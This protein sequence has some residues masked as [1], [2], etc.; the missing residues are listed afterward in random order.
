MV[1]LEC[2]YGN[3]HEMRWPDVTV[4]GT[5]YAVSL[6]ASESDEAPNH[7]YIDI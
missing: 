3:Y 1:Y 6:A 5:I 4:T 2:E 7:G